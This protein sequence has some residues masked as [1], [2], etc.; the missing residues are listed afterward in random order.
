MATSETTRG[1]S[2]GMRTDGLQSSNGT[3]T[4]ARRL[5]TETKSF[6]KTSEFV[7]Y[8]VTFIG[9]LIAANAIENADG[10]RDFFTADKAWLYITILTVGY[11][12][13]R[14]IAKAGSSDPYWA[15][16]GDSNS[17]H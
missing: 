1:R 13:S 9:I 4:P 17:N 10:G 2:D 16:R 6:F 12:I 14:G 3:G 8:I 15:E 11:M 5:S 7:A